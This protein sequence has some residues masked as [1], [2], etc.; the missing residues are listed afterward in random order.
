MKAAELEAGEVVV[1]TDS[2]GTCN[3]D[4]GKRRYSLHLPRTGSN[5]SLV[6]MLH[7]CVQPARDFAVAT[8]MNGAAA[9]RGWPTLWPEQRASANL[10]RCWNWFR[11]KHQ[12]RDQGEPAI[13]GAMIAEVCERYGIAPGCVLLAGA[14]A[15][16]A[17]A[18]ILAVTYP[19]LIAAVA[20][21]SGAPFG[22]ATN[23]FGGLSLMKKGDSDPVAL[24][25][26]AHRAMGPRARPIPA[27]VLHGGQD[28][29][30]HPQNGTRAAQQWAV[31]NLLALGQT[32]QAR[33]VPQ[34]ASETVH[35]EDGRYDAVIV[36]YQDDAGRTLA[37]EWRVPKLGHAWSGGSPEATYTDP[38]GPDATAAVIDFFS[39][40]TDQFSS[41]SSRV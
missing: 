3:V 31:T 11:A 29:K 38:R 23:V 8:K 24:G 33:V 1:G 6:V 41:S 17:M 21:H 32:V 7:G 16:A 37:E 35:H 19:E 2:V 9:A 20:I 15:G 5:E 18:S 26:L 28:R 27:M 4:A 12:S 34:P 40:A 10:M 25:A 22:A 14:S 13:L 30:V 36:R 39:H